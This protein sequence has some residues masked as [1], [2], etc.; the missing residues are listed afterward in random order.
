MS[1][2]DILN[3]LYKIS[4]LRLCII[5]YVPDY[6][7]KSEVIYSHVILSA[8]SSWLAERGQCK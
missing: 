6:L 7:N 2:K 3:Q 1:G 5:D 4:M 8:L